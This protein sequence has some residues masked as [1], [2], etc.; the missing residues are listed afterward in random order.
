DRLTFDRAGEIGL[1]HQLRRI[2]ARQLLAV[3]L[4][5][6]GWIALAGRRLD[7]EDPDAAHIHFVRLRRRDDVDADE[8]DRRE[9]REPP[10]CLRHRSLPLCRCG[11]T[12]AR[13]IDLF[14]ARNEMAKTAYS[15]VSD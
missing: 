1:P 2:L 3:L 9:Y 14:H 8:E 12:A 10:E 15:R 4:E 5:R 6:Q 13:I 11:V 7:G